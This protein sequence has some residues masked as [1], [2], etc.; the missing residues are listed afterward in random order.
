MIEKKCTVDLSI[1]ISALNESNIIVENIDEI[2]SWIQNYLPQIAYEILIIDDGSTDNMY[3]ILIEASKIRPWLK[4]VRH[5]SNK[6]RGRGIR[7]GFTNSVGNYIVCMDADLSYGPEHIEKLLR[8]LMDNEADISVASPYH[9]QGEV[10]NVPK[11]RA[12]ISRWGNKLL[13][14]GFGNHLSTVTCIVRGF[15]RKVINELELLNDGKELHL[16][17]L[18]KAKLLNYRVVEVPAS[19]V[20]RDKKRGKSNPKKII[21]ELALLKMRKTVASHLI[22]NY[23]SNPGLLLFIPILLLLGLVLTGTLLIMITFFH[24]LSVMHLSVYQTL[25]IT[26]LNGQL[27]LIIVLFSAITLMIFI[28]FYFLSFQLKYCFDELYSLSMRAHLRAKGVN[29]EQ[30]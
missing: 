23:V 22:F 21:P 12:L 5:S 16:E 14:K 27:S 28:A 17:I 4:L 2:S 7:T 30:D 13:A 26:L 10:R 15:T 29:L 18:Q 1:V 24:N 6:G 25:R 9:K 3:D 19:L 11:Q 8:P 20:W